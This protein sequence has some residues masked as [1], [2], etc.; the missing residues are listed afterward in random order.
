M[1]SV[2][3]FKLLTNFIKIINQF[4]VCFVKHL[5]YQDDKTN[6]DWRRDDGPPAP[7]SDDRRGGGFDR[8]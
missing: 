7:R 1:S 4:F 6:N 8:R 2:S 3:W 5:G